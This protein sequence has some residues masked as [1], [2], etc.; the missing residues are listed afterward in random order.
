MVDQSLLIK[1]YKDELT[2]LGFL[3]IWNIIT[4]LTQDDCDSDEAIAVIED[5]VVTPDMQAV[6]DKLMKEMRSPSLLNDNLPQIPNG[7]KNEPIIMSH[8][9]LLLRK[10]K[11]IN[12]FRRV[13][14][15]PCT[16]ECLKS[17]YIRHDLGEKKEDTC[18][19]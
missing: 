1:T 6:L 5:C 12:F 8:F 10:D 19:D 11:I 18:L 14:Y 16:R 3:G 2:S 9:F 15:P 13:G 17:P 4:D 7:M